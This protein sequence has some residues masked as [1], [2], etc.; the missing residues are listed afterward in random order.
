[1]AKSV[2]A[3]LLEYNLKNELNETGKTRY[4]GKKQK[5]TEKNWKKK[6]PKNRRNWMILHETGRNRKKQKETVR[7]RKKH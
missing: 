4:N 3:K 6:T 7:N 5:E 1:M 2:S